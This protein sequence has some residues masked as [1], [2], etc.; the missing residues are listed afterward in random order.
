MAGIEA[1]LGI[2]AALHQRDLGRGA[3]YVHVSVWEAALAWMWRD[4]TTFEASGEGWGN[5]R[6]FG[7]RYRMYRTADDRAI[8]VCPIERHFWERFCD[9]LGLS[10]EAK[11]RGDW[12]TGM[13]YGA[14]YP[15]EIEEIA[16]RMAERTLAEWEKV[17]IEAEVPVA[18]VLDWR[19]AYTSEHGDANGVRSSFEYRGR[20]VGIPTT[21]VSVSG[22]AASDSVEIKDLAAMHRS[23]GDVLGPPP[24]L[25][26]HTD[27]FLAELGVPDL[28][29]KLR[30]DGA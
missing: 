30:R 12:T 26:A 2:F 22:V 28:A 5:Y 15:G 13:D 10:S 7:A 8:L 27:E 17:L 14:D 11:S 20:T 19:E 24:L 16:G 29:A 23:K 6:D 4:L 3:Q 25:G 1:A 9:V 21:P 18:P